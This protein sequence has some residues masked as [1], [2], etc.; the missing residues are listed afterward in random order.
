MPEP[1]LDEVWTI[2]GIATMEKGEYEEAL[3]YLKRA[4]DDREV[5]EAIRRCE[6]ELETAES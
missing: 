5:R 1:M 2:L 3:S 4:P 6:E